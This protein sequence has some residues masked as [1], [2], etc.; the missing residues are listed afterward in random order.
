MVMFQEVLVCHSSS[1][2]VCDPRLMTGRTDAVVGASYIKKWDS[3]NW[4]TRR[5]FV[6][7]E[8]DIV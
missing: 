4:I 1:V 6:T 7:Q 8:P 2:R 5:E 3:V